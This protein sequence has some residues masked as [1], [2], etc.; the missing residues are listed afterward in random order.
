MLSHNLEMIIKENI[1]LP[2]IEFQHCNMLFDY[3]SDIKPISNYNFTDNKITICFNRIKDNG[4]NNGKENKSLITEAL[5]LKEFSYFSDFNLTFANKKLSLSDKAKITIQACR[6]EIKHILKDKKLNIGIAENKL[7]DEL[8]KR[9]S[10][11]DFKYRFFDDLEFE[12]SK[13]DDNINQLVKKHI[14]SNFF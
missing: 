10:Y 14:D 11:L 9:C 12:A 4:I 6:F 8:I 2:K 1:I 3:F 13:V 7:E 5:F